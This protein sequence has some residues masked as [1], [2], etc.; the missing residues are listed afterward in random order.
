MIL[1]LSICE[2]RMSN[3]HRKK[4]TMLWADLWCSRVALVDDQQY[5]CIR[6]AS[7]NVILGVEVDEGDDDGDEM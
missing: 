2:L 7:G 6:V 1:T 3:G 4:F 5:G